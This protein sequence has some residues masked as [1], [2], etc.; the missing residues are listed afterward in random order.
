[1]VTPGDLD[2]LHFI[3]VRSATQEPH[4]KAM[5]DDTYSRRPD[6]PA[7]QRVPNH[8]IQ[9]AALTRAADADRYTD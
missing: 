9:P 8:G 2:L 3:D 1:L 6:W 5:G 7:L 4:G